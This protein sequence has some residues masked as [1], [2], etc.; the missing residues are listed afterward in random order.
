MFLG[1][2]QEGDTKKV[3][4]GH[5]LHRRSSSAFNVLDQQPQFGVQCRLLQC[6]QSNYVPQRSEGEIRHDEF[7]LALHNPAHPE[8]RRVSRIAAP[9][10]VASPQ[11]LLLSC[12]CVESVSAMKCSHF[13]LY[14]Q[15]QLTI[16]FVFLK[17]EYPIFIST[18]VASEEQRILLCICTEYNC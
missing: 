16:F 17:N 11:G 18:H 13:L 8:L 7:K 15:L 1:H 4:L 6:Q 12:L 14:K 10:C 3:Y 2:L 5:T 9:W